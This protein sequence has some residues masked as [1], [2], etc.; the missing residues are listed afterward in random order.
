MGV[1]SHNREDT[2]TGIGWI[3]LA[4][5]LTANVDAVFSDTPFDWEALTNGAP[6]PRGIMIFGTGDI[7]VT[8]WSGKT[9]IYTN[10][11]LAIGVIHPM[12]I[13]TVWLSSTSITKCRLF[14]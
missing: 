3:T 4:A 9:D 1:R 8:S 12:S 14:Y 11:E 13:K 5:A 2:F 7:K 10:G 6:P